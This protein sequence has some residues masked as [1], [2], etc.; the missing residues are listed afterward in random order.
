MTFTWY[1]QIL[2]GAVTLASFYAVFKS[3]VFNSFN[4]FRNKYILKLT[5][6]PKCGI[7]DAVN[8]LRNT[9]LRYCATG[10]SITANA[11]D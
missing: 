7:P 5:A 3:M 1:L 9:Y 8:T 11:G 4:R 2:W 10:K 6:P